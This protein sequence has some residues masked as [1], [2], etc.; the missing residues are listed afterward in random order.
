MRTW[1]LLNQNHFTCTTMKPFFS[2]S[3]GYFLGF[4]IVLGCLVLWNF[5]SVCAIVCI[6]WGFLVWWG[7]WPSSSFQTSFSSSVKINLNKYMIFRIYWSCWWSPICWFFFLSTNTDLRKKVWQI[8]INW[9]L[10]STFKNV[11]LLDTFFSDL[12]DN[13]YIT[14]IYGFFIVVLSAPKHFSWANKSLF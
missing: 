9:P 6:P 3:F 5:H 7:W 2:R 8:K 13:M 4:E 14:N 12:F 10:R 11:T 1:H